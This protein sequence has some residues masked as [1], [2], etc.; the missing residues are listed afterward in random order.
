MSIERDR[1]FI[2]RWVDGGLA[3]A[4][5]HEVVP[6]N[7]GPTAS[8]GALTLNEFVCLYAFAP[9]LRIYSR[10]GRLTRPRE[11]QLRQAVLDMRLPASVP[12]HYDLE[13]TDKVWRAYMEVSAGI[14]MPMA[15]FVTGRF[16]PESRVGNSASRLVRVLWMARGLPPAGVANWLRS[17][18]SG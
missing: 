14:G 5:E 18:V 3:N 15:M 6:L 8:K 17:V 9:T 11:L 2:L 12:L 4:P 16:T 13:R 10:S 1:N 7:G